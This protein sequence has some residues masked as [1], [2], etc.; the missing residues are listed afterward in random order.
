MKNLFLS[1]F[2]IFSL[3]ACT[4]RNDDD[5]SLFYD[6]MEKCT[7]LIDLF[8]EADYEI[9]PLDIDSV[10]IPAVGMKFFA[11]NNYFLIGDNQYTHTIFLYNNQGKFLHTIGSK[12]KGPHEYSALA[13]FSVCHDTISIADVGSSEDCFSHYGLDGSFLS[14][15]KLS[16]KVVSFARNPKG[17]Y[18]INSGRN[19]YQAK[20]QITRFTNDLKVMEQYWELNEK[21]NNIP[22]FEHN[23]SNSDDDIFFHEAFNNQLYKLVDNQFEPSYQLVFDGKNDFSRVRT[24]NFMKEVD[25]LYKKGFYLLNGYVENESHVF[26]SFDCMKDAKNEKQVLGVY[27][28]NTQKGK[29]CEVPSS[30]LFMGNLKDNVLYLMVSDDLIE[31]QLPDIKKTKDTDIFILKVML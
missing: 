7:H 11:Y 20:W 14:K 30:T 12:G 3:Y 1:L 29:I 19:V 26:L 4:T 24:G 28:K 17:E 18:I 27:D 2:L 25:E 21:E 16:D 15:T 9:I 6:D 10:A 22:I 23:F 13:D 31:N 8:E 5:K